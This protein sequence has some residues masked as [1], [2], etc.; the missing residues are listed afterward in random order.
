MLHFPIVVFS[1]FTFA[2]AYVTDFGELLAV[3]FLAG[4]GFG[5]AFPSLIALSEVVG[6]GNRSIMA[7]TLMFCGMPLG[8]GS[9]AIVVQLLPLGGQWRPLFQIGGVLPLIVCVLVWLVLPAFEVPRRAKASGSG[10]RFTLFGEGRMLPTVLIWA[11]IFPTLLILYLILNWLPLLVTGKHLG[12]ADAS[13]AALAFNYAGVIGAI[14][15]GWVVDH[16]GMKGPLIVIYVGLIGS[17]VALGAVS[18]RNEV[19]FFSGLAGFCLLGSNYVLYGLVGRY[20]PASLRGSGAGAA[21]AVGRIGSVIGPLAA[22]LMLGAGATS[23]AVLVNLAP[24]AAVAGIAAI[25]LSMHR[26]SRHAAS[27]DE[28]SAM[29]R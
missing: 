9:A 26:L 20:Y 7:A 19:L 23:A 1:I 25:A 4:L 5:G 3:R 16:R 29:L 21:V 2:T 13:M 11:A 18:G 24:V 6:R 27:A 8:G 17:L 15:L 22:G 14:V 12:K 28:A 10:L